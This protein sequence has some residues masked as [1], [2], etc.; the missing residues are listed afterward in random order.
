MELYGRIY[1]ACF[2]YTSNKWLIWNYTLIWIMARLAVAQSYWHDFW[3]IC[4][5]H[6]FSSWK[7]CAVRLTI[8]KIKWPK[9]SVL[10]DAITYRLPLPIKEVMVLKSG[11]CYPRCPRCSQSLE[12]E[13]MCFCDRCGQRLDWHEFALDKVYEVVL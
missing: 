1:C 12:R 5:N 7:D 13:Y 6:Q 3:F 10:Y 9:L 4:A 11:C 2:A 8:M